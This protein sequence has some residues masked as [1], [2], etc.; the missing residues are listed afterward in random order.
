MVCI[1][2]IRWSS[3]SSFQT[4]GLIYNLDLLFCYEYNGPYEKNSD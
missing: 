3:K 1:A 4:Y 2:K